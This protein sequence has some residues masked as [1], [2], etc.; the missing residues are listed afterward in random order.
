MTNINLVSPRH[1]NTQKDKHKDKDTKRTLL[2]PTLEDGFEANSRP[3][4]GVAKINILEPSQLQQSLCILQLEKVSHHLLHC[5]SFASF[6]A[7]YVTTSAHATCHR[8]QQ[9]LGIAPNKQ[10][11]Q[12]SH[13]RAY[14][15]SERPSWWENAQ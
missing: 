6:L 11:Q 13:T 14:Q 4:P 5:P 2:R 3:M 8:S 10:K 9:S 12:L 1:K 7:L 15:T